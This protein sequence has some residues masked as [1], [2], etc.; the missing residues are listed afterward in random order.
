MLELSTNAENEDLILD[1]FGGSGSTGHSVLDLNN[2]D[3]GNRKFILVQLPESTENEPDLVKAGYKKISDVT[4][5]RNKKVVEKLIEEKKNKQ[6]DLFTNGHKEDAIKGLGFKVF[7]LVKSNFPRVEWAPDVDKTEEENIAL[8]KKYI[9]DKEAQL[10]TAF[11][12][13]ELL[14]E[15]LLKNGFQL[16]YK[17]YKQD[18][19]KKNEILLGTDGI[20]ET[21]ICL[22]VTVEAD[23]VEYFKKHTDKKFICLERALDTTKKYNLKHYL[24][25]LFNAF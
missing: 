3:N 23:T 4:I 11:N 25:D 13:N 5:D 6:P 21:L 10:V 15:I 22:D 2:K 18:Q 24:G 14:T 12:R 19:F 20:K 1:F 16:N 9:A 8:L 17:A 7:K